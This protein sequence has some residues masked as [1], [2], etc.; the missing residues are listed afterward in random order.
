MSLHRG[1]IDRV[2]D[3]AGAKT[4]NK[5]RF[6]LLGPEFSFR[7]ERDYQFQ[8]HCVLDFVIHV[9]T[10]DEH[11]LISFLGVASI[12]HPE[13]YIKDFNKLAWY[14]PSSYAWPGHNFP[15]FFII[16]FPTLPLKTLSLKNWPAGPDPTSFYE[17]IVLYHCNRKVTHINIF[18]PFPQYRPPPSPDKVLTHSSYFSIAVIEH[19]EQDILWDRRVYLCMWFQRARVHNVRAEEVTKATEKPAESSQFE[20]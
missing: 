8:S 2:V 17:V 14:K 15:V 9:R 12:F 6:Q 19:H 4:S 18:L 10:F 1:R 20:P 7:W 16:S 5:L 3:V 13:N 11:C